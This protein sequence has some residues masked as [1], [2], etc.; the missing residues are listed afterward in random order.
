MGQMILPAEIINRLLE[1]DAGLYTVLNRGLHVSFLDTAMRALSMAGN[2]GLIW[3]AA[4]VCAMAFF[5]PQA[6]RAG[7]L[8]LLTLLFSYLVNDGLLKDFFHRSRPYEVLGG[9]RLL[10]APLHSPSFPSGHAAC[11]F[12]C[13]HV[14]ARKFSGLARPFYALAALMSFSRV[15]VGAHYP[16]DVL[17]GALLG[18]VCAVLALKAESVLLSSAKKTR[19]PTF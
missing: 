6:R 16:S 19:P 17:A 10:V 9:V 18:A 3:I 12:A 14:M 8:M 2:G 4:G 13:A 1:F 11:A 7:A 5:G 15:Y